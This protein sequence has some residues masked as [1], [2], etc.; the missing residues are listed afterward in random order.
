M[1]SQPA[2]ADFEHYQIEPVSS[3]NSRGY[4][5]PLSYLDDPCRPLRDLCDVVKRSQA[6]KSLWLP[7][8]FSDL[9][10]KIS[11]VL[12]ARDALLEACR[13]KGV[14]V[15]WRLASRETE[16]DRGVSREFWEY[17]RELKRRKRVEAM[18]GRSE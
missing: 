10:P 13:A 15:R 4:S 17:A 5:H 12:H 2:L 16:D 7:W 18:K 8:D 6:L 3:H 9:N 1:L 14:E 11:D